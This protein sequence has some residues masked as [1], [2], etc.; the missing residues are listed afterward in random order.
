MRA[1]HP[2]GTANING[3]TVQKLDTAIG[4]LGGFNPLTLTVPV[5]ITS[6]TSL[7]ASQHGTRRI[8]FRSFISADGVAFTL[9]NT[10]SRELASNFAIRAVGEVP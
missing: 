10:I 1:T 6:G 8:F 5:T 3:L 4:A 9:A 2:G 7:S